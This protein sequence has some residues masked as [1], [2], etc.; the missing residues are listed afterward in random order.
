M[1]TNRLVS[2]LPEMAIFV[3]V[4][5]QESFSRVG[6]KL[7]IAPSSISRS[8][9]KLENALATKLLERTTR[10][11]HLS[12]DGKEVYDL[13][14]KMLNSAKSAVDAA[15]SKQDGASGV[16]RIAAPKAFS[17]QVLAE[18]V[19]DFLAE[20][21]LITVKLKVADHFVDPVSE[22]VDLVI[23]L[24]NQPVQGLVSR[25][26]TQTNL[27]LCASPEYIAEHGMPMH[28][29][30]LQ[31]HQCITLG[32]DN[33]DSRW[34]LTKDKQSIEIASNGR[35]AVNH[36][37]IRK[38]S[39]LRGIGI[40]VFPDF[41]IDNELNKGIVVPV[42]P[43][44]HIDGNYQGMVVAQYTQSRFVPKKIRKFIEFAIARLA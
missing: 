42:L 19:L 1:D 4:A 9:S 36:T 25:V 40:S 12:N 5:E 18:I 16:L 6:K 31:H 41:S 35:F 7:N 2:L 15:Q 11:V 39:V 30:D 23:R 21:P 44:W 13:C 37:E 29:N 43:D 33:K 20:N 3:M 17:K 34:T 26:L 8:I 28:P 22:E 24:T 38:E 14:R 27:L 10:K 32:E